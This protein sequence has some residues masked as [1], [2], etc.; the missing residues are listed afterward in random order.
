VRAGFATRTS[1]NGSQTVELARVPEAG[2][3]D[4]DARVVADDEEVDA[5]LETGGGPDAVSA[6]DLDWGL[7]PWSFDG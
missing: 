3:D 7:P 4:G 6:V 5:V 1:S 2:D